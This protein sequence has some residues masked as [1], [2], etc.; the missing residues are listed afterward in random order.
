MIEQLAVHEVMHRRL[1][2][3]AW[4]HA[5]IK[6]H[7]RISVKDFRRNKNLNNASRSSA[8]K[9]AGS[10]VDQKGSSEVASRS[11]CNSASVNAPTSILSASAGCA[12]S[13]RDWAISSQASSE[14]FRSSMVLTA[15]S[16]FFVSPS[17]AKLAAGRHSRH[18]WNPVTHAAMVF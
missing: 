12:S 10:G 6:A 8:S 5:F 4:Y 17:R 15:S 7:L 2:Q 11:P 16:V 1:F 14:N 9:S 18:L 3:S 13:Q